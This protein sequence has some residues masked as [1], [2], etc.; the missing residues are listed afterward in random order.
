MPAT[1]PVGLATKL[2][3]ALAAILGA[4]TVIQ[5][6]LAGDQSDTTIATLAG[7]VVTVYKIMDGRYQQ[8]TA[9]TAVTADVADVEIPGEFEPDPEEPA[10]AEQPVV[11][12]GIAT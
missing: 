7:L 9:A 1:I 4:A 11:P 2:G 12:P 5:A 10:P 8:A 6:F 3:A